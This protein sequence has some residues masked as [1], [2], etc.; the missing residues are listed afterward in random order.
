MP[1]HRFPIRFERA[2]AAL[3]SAVLLRPADAYMELD[4]REVRVR[5][6]WAFRARF[7]RAAAATATPWTGRTLSRGVHGLRGRWLVNGAGSGIVEVT[8]R[9]AQRAW[10]MAFPVRL[11]TLLVSVEDPA[12]LVAA[13]APA[14]GSPPAAP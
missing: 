1:S 8:L 12:A 4:E 6:G 10:V 11:A 13:L 14:S 9:P 3:S 7:P 5:M 2:Y